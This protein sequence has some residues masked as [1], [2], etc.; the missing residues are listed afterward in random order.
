MVMTTAT[1]AAWFGLSVHLLGAGGME[2]PAIIQM[3]LCLSSLVMGGGVGSER[4]DSNWWP[5][6]LPMTVTGI[7]A[8]A[9]LG[10]MVTATTPALMSRALVHLAEADSLTGRAPDRILERLEEAAAADGLD[11]ESWRRMAQFALVRW[12]QTQQDSDFE[13]AVEAQKAA[14]ARDPRNPHDQRGLAD[15]YLVRFGAGR[16]ASDAE[17]AVLAS[18]ESLRLYP[19]QLSGRRVLAES[20]LAAGQTAESREAA[21]RTLELDQLWLELGHFD[22]VLTPAERE[23]VKK[24]AGVE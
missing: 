11:P 20:L 10:Q 21:Q 19:N 13:R 5:T 15:L 14:V 12:K 2:M 6:W 18:R 17:A 22:K 3:W 7:G 4:R 1:T 8:A 24:L 23:R 9:F 16:R